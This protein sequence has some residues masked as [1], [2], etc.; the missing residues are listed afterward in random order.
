MSDSALNA[1][2][3]AR[4]LDWLD[5]GGK[6]DLLVIGGG[7][8]GAGVALD[9]ASRGLSVV[10]AEKHDLAFGTSRWSSKLI[11]G[12][13]RYLVSGKVGI[14]HES[15]VERGI[16]MRYTA[17]HLVHPI[18]TVA[19]WLPQ[20]SIAQA[21]MLRA[22]Y[23]GG[24]MLR[25]AAGTS[26]QLLP[27]SR[28][29]SNA[30]VLRY[31]PTVRPD[32]LR[33]GLIDWDGQVYDDARLVVA[34]ARTAARYGA[35]I[36]TYCSADDASGRGAV[37]TDRLSGRTL[38]VQA[39]AVVNATGI[40]AGTV[41][42]GIKLRPSRGTHLVL[43]QSAFGGLSAVLTVPVPGQLRRVVMAIPAPDGRVYVGL[44]DEDAPGPVP[45]VPEPTD[46]EI[47]FLLSIISAAVAEPITRADLLGAYAG[48]RPLLD[49]G[50]GSTADLSR[51]HAVITSQD[52][53]MT[54][55]GGKLTTYRRMAQDAVDAAVR[56]AGLSAGRCRTSRLPLVGAAAPRSLARVAAPRRLVQRY[57]V[58]ALDVLRLAGDDPALL[59]PLTPGIPTT[60][61][62]LLFGIR[63]EGALT[64]DDLLDRRTRIGL[65]ATDRQACL[66]AAEAAT[67]LLATT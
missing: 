35:R 38:T 1:A 26:G 55:V 65:C 47:D 16:L 10:L 34:V 21:T 36:L 62:E 56:Q 24:D 6:V 48:L 63:N 29:I 13:L 67:A 33:G 46:G 64:P 51:R 44:T 3:R 60:R 59:E 17:P 52:G 18:P 30:E 49:T 31:A 40:W 8:T 43:P 66:P 37:L 32:G 28:R 7:I 14:A 41:A 9:A 22:A 5:D 42:P 4:D 45:D 12:G 23:L 19:P 20:A 53:L 2:R 25:F 27:R 39:R 58:E 50:A 15:A 54:I 57:G 61:A 11:H